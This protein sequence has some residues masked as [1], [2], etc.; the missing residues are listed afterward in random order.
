[1]TIC[2]LDMKNK[3]AVKRGFLSLFEHK[4]SSLVRKGGLP[5]HVQQFAAVGFRGEKRGF[6]V[7]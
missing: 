7:S 1:M 6:G 2:T 3:L 5:Y 4:R